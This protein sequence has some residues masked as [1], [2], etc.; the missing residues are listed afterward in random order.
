M[1]LADTRPPFLG[2]AKL[3]DEALTSLPRRLS[4]RPLASVPA[5]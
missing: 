2:L 1:R 3:S 4:Y 5:R